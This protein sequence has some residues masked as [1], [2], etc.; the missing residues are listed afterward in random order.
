MVGNWRHNH[1][2]RSLYPRR[3]RHGNY[4]RDLDAR[5]DKVRIEQRCGFGGNDHTHHHIG[6]SLM[7]TILDYHGTD[8]HLL[9]ERE[10]DGQL[11]F[12][13]NM[14]GNWRL[15]HFCGSLYPQRHR[16]GNH[17]RNLD[18]RHVQVR[19]EQHCGHGG[20]NGHPI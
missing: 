18:T 1:V 5:H 20:S 3:H 11:Q 14:V 15:S 4:H 2:R 17:H 7:L 13:G 9:G 10:W 6:D 16:H 8:Q 12:R 19:I